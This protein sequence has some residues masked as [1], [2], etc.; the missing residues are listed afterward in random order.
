MAIIGKSS[1]DLQYQAGMREKEVRRFEEEITGDDMKG[2]SQHSSWWPNKVDNDRLIEMIIKRHQ[3]KT[4]VSSP[5]MGGQ[6]SRSKYVK[7][8]PKVSKKMGLRQ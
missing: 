7:P 1:S 3:V 5:M 8:G 6:T 2:M 4:K